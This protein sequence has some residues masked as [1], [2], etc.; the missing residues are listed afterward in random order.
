ML[1]HWW[2][3]S[4]ISKLGILLKTEASFI[5]FF[6]FKN[7]AGYLL[8]IAC[9]G[10]YK[11]SKMETFKENEKLQECILNLNRSLIGSDI[12]VIRRKSDFI[13]AS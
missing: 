10:I 6:F 12:Y 4:F 7:T 2:E 1:F 11:G 5:V 3:G 9:R 8:L 13:G